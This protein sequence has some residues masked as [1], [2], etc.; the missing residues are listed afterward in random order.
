HEHHQRV[1]A[2]E[3]PRRADAE[4]QG[5]QHQVRGRLDHQRSTSASTGSASAGPPSGKPRSSSGSG[6]GGAGNSSRSIGSSRVRRD[7][8]TAPTTAIT[9]RADVSSK[10]KT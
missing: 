6:S 3:E 2:D 5:R 7:S 10:A 4:E 9:S 8:T 1:A